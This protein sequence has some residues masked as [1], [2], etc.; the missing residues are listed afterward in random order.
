MFKELYTSDRL[1]AIACNAVCFPVHEALPPPHPLRKCLLY[2]R[3]KM[4]LYRSPNYQAGLE[5]TGLSVQEKVKYRLSRWQPWRTSWI[6][7]QNDFI[8]FLQVTSIL[9]RK[10]RVSWPFGLRENVQYKFSTWPLW[11]PYWISDRNNFSCFD[12]QVIP[13]LPTVSSKLAFPFRSS[14]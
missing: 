9:P 2:K 7:N 12:L 10:F 11:R 3:A 8:Y 1:S 6:S 5:S 14:K 13:I 4:A